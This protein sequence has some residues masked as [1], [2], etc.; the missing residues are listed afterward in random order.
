MAIAI[1][2]GTWRL[3]ISL[4]GLFLF[5]LTET[6]WPFKPRQEPQSKH[7]LVNLT[8]GAVNT[9]VLNITISSLVVAYF[10]W[11]S[12]R[13]FGLLNWMGVGKT[14]N[15][16]FSFL[17]LDFM[18][19]LWHWAYHEVPWMWRL[20]RVHHSDL[21]LDV[22]SASRFHLGELLWS[23]AFK[24]AVGFFW[25]THPIALAVHEA[26]LLAAAQLQHANFRIPEPWEGWLKRLI[27]TPDMHR[28]HHSDNPRETN[29]NYS[30][31]FSFWDRLFGT[32]TSP[33]NQERLRIGLKEYP[34]PADVTLGKLLAMPFREGP[35]SAQ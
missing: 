11:L 10:D 27:V 21:D 18:T 6:L 16:L 30:N 25:G 31:F 15:I 12:D 32:Y 14:A 23:T 2:T 4:G 8:M 34:K 7:Y 1:E 35:A 28:I 24:M 9:L 22:T 26:G 29:S 5:S 17:F 33:V 19:Y 20:H 13:R 3:L